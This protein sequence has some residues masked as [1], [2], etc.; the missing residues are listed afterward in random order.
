MWYY[1]QHER[2]E[3]LLEPVVQYNMETLIW[4]T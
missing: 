1:F 2:D 4:D 3:K